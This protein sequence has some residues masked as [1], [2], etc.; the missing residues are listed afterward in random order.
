[1]KKTKKAVKIMQQDPVVN[2]NQTG[3]DRIANKMAVYFEE[4]VSA[5]NLV[6][7]VTT[8]NSD[9]TPD[10][11]R[12]VEG[13]AWH[14]GWVLLPELIN[15]ESK[16]NRIEFLKEGLVDLFE[17]AFYKESKEALAQIGINFLTPF[18]TLT[19]HHFTVAEFMNVYATFLSIVEMYEEYEYY[20][21]E[22]RKVKKI[23]KAA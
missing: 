9:N 7:W 19:D 11:I 4:R 16:K 3:M 6:R 17:N 14:L 8:V 15:C 12:D 1:M 23:S 20:G 2:K 22:L 21:N 18:A 10:N 13:F 5:S